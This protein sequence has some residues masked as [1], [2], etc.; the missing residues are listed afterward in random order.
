MKKMTLPELSKL[1][2]IILVP[3]YGLY[4]GATTE[5]VLTLEDGTS[6]TV[7][8]TTEKTDINVGTIETT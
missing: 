8:V 1:R 7:E 6:T 3:I 4:N 5:V 2:R